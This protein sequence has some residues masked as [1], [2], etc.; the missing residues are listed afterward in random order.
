MAFD[1][2]GFVIAGGA[3]LALGA[4]LGPSG[5]GVAVIRVTAAL[6]MNP[7]PDG[8][9]RPLMLTVVQLKSS[10]VFDGA[11]FF[12]LQNP[13][14][15][16]GGDLLK[17]DQII[18]ISGESANKVIDVEVGAAFIGVIA[19]FRSPAGKVSNVPVESA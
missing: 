19:G 4:C 16:L 15:A 9:D 1:R 5:P 13:A 14:D 17:V 18:L 6:G 2:R 8:G 10:A 7:G 12:A 11:D 3:V